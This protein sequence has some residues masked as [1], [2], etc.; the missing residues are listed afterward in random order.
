MRTTP[1]D[2]DNMAAKLSK[3]TGTDLRISWAYGKPRLIRMLA[4]GGEDEIS[5]RL[6][7]GELLQWMFAFEEGFEFHKRGG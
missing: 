1:K 2:L 6:Q 4:N 5:P 7:S 3:L